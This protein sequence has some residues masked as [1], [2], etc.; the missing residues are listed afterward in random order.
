MKKRLTTDNPQNNIE[1]MLNYAYAKVNVSFSVAVSQKE[2]LTFATIYHERQKNITAIMFR[3][4][5]MLWTV[6]VWKWA[7]IAFFPYFTRLQHRQQNFENASKDMRMQ[8]TQ[9]TANG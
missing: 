9:R 1:R 8:R 5:M 7:A 2:T 3:P 6:P 4:Q